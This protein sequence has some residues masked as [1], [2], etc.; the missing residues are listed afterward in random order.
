VELEA[1]R[2]SLPFRDPSLGLGSDSQS[3]RNATITLLWLHN[4]LYSIPNIQQNS[5]GTAKGIC[6]DRGLMGLGNMGL[7]HCL[8]QEGL[9]LWCR[10]EVLAGLTGSSCSCL[11]TPASASLGYG[12]SLQGSQDLGWDAA[13][14][15]LWRCVS[16]AGILVVSVSPRAALCLRGWQKSGPYIARIGPVQDPG[17]KRLGGS[18]LR[19]VRFG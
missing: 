14:C 18:K 10:R 3:G 13:L 11:W 12:L 16:S 9:A 15:W 6:W 7:G 5:Q 4:Q 2:T 17:G 19:G 1:T 8:G